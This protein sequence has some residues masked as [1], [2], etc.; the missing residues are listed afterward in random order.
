MWKICNGNGWVVCIHEKL[1]KVMVFHAMV[2]G[3]EVH[4]IVLN[5]SEMVEGQLSRFPTLS[6]RLMIL[7]D[8]LRKRT[9]LWKKLMFLS[10]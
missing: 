8:F 9:N 7:F 4:E 3:E 10:P 2:H 6:L 5:V 1:G